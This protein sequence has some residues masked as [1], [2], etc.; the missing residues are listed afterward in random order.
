MMRLRL[1]ETIL[2]QTTEVNRYE[3]T[4]TRLLHGYPV[5]HIHR[6]HGHFVVGNN[7]ELRVLAELL[8]HIRKLTH[9]GI[10][11]RS[12]YLIED[13]ERRGFD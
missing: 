7:N 5:D 1:C 8:D 2:V 13:T 10:I 12:I 4:Y 11:E 6:T 3:F 9:V